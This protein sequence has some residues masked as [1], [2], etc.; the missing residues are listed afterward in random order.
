MNFLDPEFL[1]PILKGKPIAATP[2]VT[3]QLQLEAG[4]LSNQGDWH[5]Q[6]I[7]NTQVRVK[8]DDTVIYENTVDAGVIALE[9]SLANE[10]QH[11]PHC[12][13]ISVAGLDVFRPDWSDE[14]N[15]VIKIHSMKID[16]V[17]VTSMLM[18][19]SN[20]VLCSGQSHPVSQ[21][22]LYDG[23]QSLMFYAPIY[24][25]ILENYVI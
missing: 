11:T 10:N 15:P 16:D 9:F 14:I 5:C 21:Y 23:K 22:L 19:H 1:K 2:V 12:L 25:W 6:F 13:T 18:A 4:C 24:R 3:I 17:D 20:Y 8:I 7:N